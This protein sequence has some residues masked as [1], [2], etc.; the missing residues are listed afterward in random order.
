MNSRA[1]PSVEAHHHVHSPDTGRNSRGGQ[2]KKKLRLAGSVAR[3]CQLIN[4]E[5]IIQ[6]NV[7]LYLLVLKVVEV[8]EKCSD[9][10]W[11]AQQGLM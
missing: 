9:P 10:N 4:F 2:I 1:A 8:G 7:L 11:E 5:V 6:K 3:M